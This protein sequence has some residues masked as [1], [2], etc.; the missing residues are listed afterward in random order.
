MT[1]SLQQPSFGIC[2]DVDG[3]LARGTIPLDA[4]RKAFDKLVDEDRNLKVP[5]TFVTNALNRNCDKAKQIEDW[6][7]TPVSHQMNSIFHP[8]TVKP[9]Q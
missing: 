5:V 8:T 2:F 9:L 6:L 3:V 7:G 4:A 1:S